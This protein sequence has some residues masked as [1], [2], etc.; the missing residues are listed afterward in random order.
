MS[1][2]SYSDGE[3]KKKYDPFPLWML[4]EINKANLKHF[5]FNPKIS[6]NASDVKMREL[7]IK[8]GEECKVSMSF[9]GPVS[10]TAVSIK[11]KNTS[12]RDILLRLGERYGFL[13]ELNETEEGQT[14]F[15]IR[16]IKIL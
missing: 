3:K 13:Y 5:M 12:F 7:L 14:L 15:Y 1:V 11:A 16:K 6:V 4:S 9:T 10:D 2:L 8:L